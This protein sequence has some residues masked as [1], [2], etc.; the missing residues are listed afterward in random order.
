M[1]AVWY[2]NEILE[3]TVTLYDATKDSPFVFIDKAYP[4]RVNVVDNYLENERI[5]YMDMSWLLWTVLRLHVSDPVHFHT[6]FNCFVG[7]MAIG[8]ALVNYLMVSL[9]TC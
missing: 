8:S 7:R 9:V 2:G 6:I 4:H 5:E 1:V 3:F